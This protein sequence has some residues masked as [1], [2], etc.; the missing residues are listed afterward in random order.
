MGGFHSSQS[1]GI[2]GP[3]GILKRGYNDQLLVQPSNDVIV[4]DPNVWKQPQNYQQ[5][6]TKYCYEATTDTYAPCYKKGKTY[7]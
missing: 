5:R 2:S 3:Q 4:G 6:R 1:I 7:K